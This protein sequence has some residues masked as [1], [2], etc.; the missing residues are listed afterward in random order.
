MRERES[1][2]SRQRSAWCGVGLVGLVLL[3]AFSA[4]TDSTA[5]AESSTDFW[6]PEQGMSWQ[7]QLDEPL[8]GDPLPVQVYDLDGF[9]TDAATVAALQASGIR[10][11]CYMSMGT[12]EDWRPDAGAFPVEVIGNVWDEWPDE[13]FLDIRRIDL[14]APILIARLDLCASK[15]FDAVDPDNIDIYGSSVDVIGF[16]LTE[17]DQLTF[18]RWLAAAA[19]ERGLAIGQKNAPELAES[20]VD[21]FD[22][23]VTEDCLDDTW[24]DLASPYLDA[25]KAV[26]AIEYTDRMTEADFLAACRVQSAPFSFV[27]K[28]RALDAWRQDCH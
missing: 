5:R 10:V 24:C 8:D 7:I 11:I 4:I 22:F 2:L 16:P 27:L 26:F 28:H 20:L 12:W 19:H 25:G 9:D 21:A 23:M 3:I 17:E 18:N 13:R 15:G 14:L 6:Q 1:E